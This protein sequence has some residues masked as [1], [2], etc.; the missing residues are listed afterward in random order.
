MLNYDEEICLI[1]DEYDEI[2]SE[3]APEPNKWQRYEMGLIEMDIASGVCWH[4]ATRQKLPL[5]Q[6]PNTEQR[7]HAIRREVAGWFVQMEGKFIPIQ[8]KDS[9]LRAAE[10]EKLI[11][12]TLAA[13]YPDDEQIERSKDKL[14]FAALYGTEADPR[15]SFGVYSGKAYPCPGNPSPRLYRNGMW[16]FNTW[17]QPAYR[18]LRPSH[19]AVTQYCPFEAMLAFAIP[20]EIQRTMLLDWIAWNLQNEGSKPN[21]AV[22]LYSETKGTGKST[23]AK[24]LTA[25]FGPENTAATNG[26]RSLTQR[27]AADTLDRKLVVAEE[28]HISSHST[29]GNALKDLITN[30]VVSVER[31][32]Q[33]IVTIPQTSCFLFM[34]NHKPLW[35]EGGERRYYIIQMDH[36][37]HAQ[38]EQ[39]ELFSELAGVV[40]E[41]ATNPQFIRDLY[42]RLMAR[43]LSPAF[44]P[45]NLRFSRNA[46][47]I[48]RELQ[49]TSGNEG[50]EVLASMLAQYKVQIILSPDFPEL[51]AHLRLRNANSLRNML[52]KHGWEARRISFGGNQY[53]AWCVKGLRIDNGRVDCAEL[54]QT[55]S[56]LAMANGYTWFDLAY[57]VDVTW[58]RLWWE[59]LCG[60][61]SSPQDQYEGMDNFEGEFGPFRSSTSHLRLQARTQEE[62]SEDDGMSEHNPT[63]IYVL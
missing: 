26:I 45:K 1:E 4:P 42:Q 36:S 17:M 57:F 32:Y 39:N 25:L 52:A 33:P 15:L 10:V 11:P 9:R 20:D 49:A 44:D 8:N 43:E 29:E 60:K 61:R 30:N 24:I 34:T 56:P 62:L 22:M 51:A 12:Q 35:L 27:F 3:H 21:W 48:M 59:R 58:K 55:Y 38:G 53:R 50:E 41:Q 23:I 6:K 14:T 7:M 2:D 13:A 37:G 18:T 31:K 5:P 47:P 16:D 40:N 46:T 63:R 28:V 54:A 19:D